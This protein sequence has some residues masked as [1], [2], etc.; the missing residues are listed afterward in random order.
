[1]KK[2]LVLG[3]LITLLP[4]AVSG[5]GRTETPLPREVSL[6]LPGSFNLRQGR[7]QCGPYS[8]RAVIYLITGKIVSP[9]EINRRT[10]WRM[11]N[12]MTFPWGIEGVLEQYNV[13]SD[14]V[15]KGSLSDDEKI[16]WLKSR[17]TIGKPIIL[18]NLTTGNILHW[19]TIVGYTDQRFD[20]YDSYRPAGTS[21]G[22]T[23]DENGLRPGNRS[24]TYKDLL[25]LWSAGRYGPFAWVALEIK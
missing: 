2:F 4:C 1:M 16:Q 9:N 5:G 17:L 19:F 22:Q 6:K 11:E 12:G 13:A 20:V 10:G 14:L 23:I 18:L 8:A 21:P 24:L 3:F 15:M 7:N 25:H